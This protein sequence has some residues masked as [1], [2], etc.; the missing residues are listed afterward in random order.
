MI[1]LME[2]CKGIFFFI[3][4][5]V[6]IFFLRGETMIW[7]QS[8]IITK[9]ILMPG[10]LLFCGIMLWYILARIQ[11]GYEEEKA[12]QTKLY[13]KFFMIGTGIGIVLAL[14]YIII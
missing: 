13:T 12:D 4:M 6:G 7:Q 2:V 11:I 8:Y 9:E 5:L 1:F 3:T 14:I 10:Y